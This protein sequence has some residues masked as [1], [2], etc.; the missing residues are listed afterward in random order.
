MDENWNNVIRV[1]AIPIEEIIERS[2][3]TII[4]NP[5][6]VTW[7]DKYEIDERPYNDYYHELISYVNVKKFGIEEIKKWL[8]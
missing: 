1:Y 6:R 2:S 7:Y 3:I 4:E 5:S 8:S